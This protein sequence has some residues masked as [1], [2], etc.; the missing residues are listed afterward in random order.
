MDSLE[1]ADRHARLGP[2]RGEQVVPLQ[3]ADQDLERLRRRPRVRADDRHHP[4]PPGQH[5]PER[6]PR[7]HRGLPRAAR[8]RERELTA[9]RHRLL[10]P[11]QHADV[12]VAPAARER[13]RS[14]RLAERPQGLGRAAAPRPVLDARQVAD[15]ATGARHRRGTRRGI[16]LVLLV[17]ATAGAAHAVRLPREVA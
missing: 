3:L 6:R 12:V 4:A 13:L 14:V 11:P 10:E 15:V 9:D 17:G 5:R 1:P 2:V 7:D 8:H 16:R